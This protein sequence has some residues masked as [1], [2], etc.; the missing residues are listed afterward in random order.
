MRPLTSLE[1]AFI[2]VT[3]ADRET[4]IEVRNKR[5]GQNPNVGLF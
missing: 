1:I 3:F 4:L 5:V 2:G